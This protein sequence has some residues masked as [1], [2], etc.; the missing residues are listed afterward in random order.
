MERNELLARQDAQEQRRKLNALIIKGPALPAENEVKANRE[1]SQVATLITKRAGVEVTSDDLDLVRFQPATEEFPRCCF[2]RFAETELRM[3]VYAARAHARRNGLWMEEYLTS[4]RHKL[5][6]KLRELKEQKMIKD[7]VTKNGDVF[8]ILNSTDKREG[9]KGKGEEVP[10]ERVLV[11]TDTQFENL[12]KLTKGVLSEEDGMSK[13]S[14]SASLCGL[15][16]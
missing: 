6:M 9:G 14:S 13:A 16:K 5:L 10:A 15:R 2:V 11:V 7:V 8:A 12:L 4:I 3:R 1:V